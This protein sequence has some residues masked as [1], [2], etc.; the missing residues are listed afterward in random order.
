MIK[1]TNRKKTSKPKRRKPVNKIKDK[2]K[3]PL[4]AEKQTGNQGQDA[5]KS[6]SGVDEAVGSGNVEK[7]R[8]I[9][10]GAQM[11]DY[12]KRFIRLEE[13]MFKE[14]K[15]LRDD[16]IVEKAFSD[17]AAEYGAPVRKPG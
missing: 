8:D 4:A 3:A 15:D 11:R 9:L 6:Q 10:F 7:I 16:T 2:S 12:E 14:M 1:T 5:T 17:F 13:R